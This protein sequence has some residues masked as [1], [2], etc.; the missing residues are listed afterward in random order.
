M[1]YYRNGHKNKQQLLEHPRDTLIKA[2]WN[3]GEGRVPPSLAYNEFLKAWDTWV[4]KGGY[5]P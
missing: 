3:M 4:G 1:D 5:A 2:G